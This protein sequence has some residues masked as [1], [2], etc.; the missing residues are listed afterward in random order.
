MIVV[1]ALPERVTPDLLE[2]EARW[3]PLMAYGVTAE[4]LSDVLP[5]G[6]TVN[7]TTIRNDALQV[8]ERME[9][10]LG[11]EQRGF[12]EG[13][14]RDW[15]ET[16]ISGPPV[17]VGIDGGYVRSWMDR[18]A[19]FE[20]IAGQV[21]GGAGGRRQRGRADAPLRLRGRPRRQAPDGGCTRCCASRAWA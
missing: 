17:T 19:N 4:R 13:C 12:V 7:A 18:P 8:A 6:D 1:A 5:V 2:L 20:V 10:E 21:G 15:D 16:P 3:T 9:A 11:P 14:P